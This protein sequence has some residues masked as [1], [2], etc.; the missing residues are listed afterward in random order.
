MTDCNTE[1]DTSGWS[2]NLIEIPKPCEVPWDSMKGNDRIRFCDQCSKNVY[3]ISDMSES[4]AMKLLIDSEGKVCI[5]ML[6][7]ADGTIVS[8]NCPPI[9]RPV[10]NSYRK[11]AAVISAAIALACSH[12]SAFAADAKKNDKG[13]SQANAAKKD[14][15]CEKVKAPAKADGGTCGGDTLILKQGNGAKL[16]PP[17]RLGGAIAPPMTYAGTGSNGKHVELS[18]YGLDAL[19]KSNYPEEIGTQIKCQW[20]PNPKTRKK[21][22]AISFWIDQTGKVINANVNVSSGDDEADKAA[23]SAVQNAGPFKLPAEPMG[24]VSSYNVK[25]PFD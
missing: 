6:K 13:A 23:L 11:L 9:L 8:D 3:N 22:V 16:P 2:L 25:F 4:Q 18:G 20:H 19:A 17:V 14:A 12:A 15:A 5:S 21:E 7:R 1:K 10:R 24:R